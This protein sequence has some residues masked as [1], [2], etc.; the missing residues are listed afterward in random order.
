MNYSTNK[1]MGTHNWWSAQPNGSMNTGCV[2]RVIYRSEFI[3]K[4]V[5]VL[6]FTRIDC[7]YQIRNLIFLGL[8]PPDHRVTLYT[9]HWSSL[10][11]IIVIVF[12]FWQTLELVAG[13]QIDWVGD[14]PPIDEPACGFLGEKCI[15]GPSKIKL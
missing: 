15:P 11:W 3:C 2:L 7:N 1:L 5:A 6:L 10:T 4:T 9:P 12:L 14:G 13:Q 8:Q